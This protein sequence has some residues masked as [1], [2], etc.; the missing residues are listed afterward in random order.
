M[1]HCVQ[2]KLGNILA[3]ALNQIRRSRFELF[4]ELDKDKIIGFVT[5]FIKE[6]IGV[7]INLDIMRAC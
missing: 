3:I 4:V 7:F 1:F 5:K 2:A 6:A